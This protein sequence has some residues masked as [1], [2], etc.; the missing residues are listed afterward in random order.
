MRVLTSLSCLFCPVILGSRVLSVLDSIAE[1]PGFKSQ[2][3]VAVLG[4]LF[5]PIVPLFT[6]QRNWWQLRN[7]TR[8]NRVWAT[9]TFYQQNWKRGKTAR[10]RTSPGASCHEVFPATTAPEGRQPHRL[11]AARHSSVRQSSETCWRTSPRPTTSRW[12]SRPQMTWP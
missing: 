8:G 3:R 5:T 11:Q 6:K 4:K 1:G 9:F 12:P 2:L 7:S 10:K